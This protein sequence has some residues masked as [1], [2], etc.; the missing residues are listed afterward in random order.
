[1]LTFDDYPFTLDIHPVVGIPPWIYA[2]MGKCRMQDMGRDANAVT[3]GDIPSLEWVLVHPNRKCRVI[4]WLG[5]TKNKMKPRLILLA[6][7][8]LAVGCAEPVVNTPARPD[9][10]E[11]TRLKEELERL[12]AKVKTRRAELAKLQTQT[13]GVSCE[14]KR[15]S[16]KTERQIHTLRTTT[17]IEFSI[18]GRKPATPMPTVFIPGGSANQQLNVQVIDPG[19][20][21][22]VVEYGYLYVSLDVPSHGEDLEPGEP[23]G[24]IEGWRYRVENKRNFVQEFNQKISKVLDFLIA[25][26]YTDPD[27]VAVIAG[28]RGGF[29]A[30]HYAASDP[31][32]KCVVGWMPVT[33]LGHLMEF[34][35]MENDPLT[36]SL[37]VINQAEKFV[38]RNVLVIIGDQDNRV[39]TDHAIAFARRVS[40]V[41][42]GANVTLHVLDEPRGHFETE[43]TYALTEAWLLKHLGRYRTL[44]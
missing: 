17:G 28:S 24:G 19:H 15:D 21:G 10:S 13:E 3:M 42:K 9:E 43:G 7:A 44:K 34:K 16:R 35:G 8:L 22:F 38:G 41:A 29:L 11:T 4:G 32:V 20:F 30:F 40:K 12:W 14:Q 31:R 5:A 26:G 27:R 2:T 23:L 18:V 39:G 6:V 1:M 25:E 37:A 33:D 36:K